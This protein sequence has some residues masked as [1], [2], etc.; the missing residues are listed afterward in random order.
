MPKQRKRRYRVRT[1]VRLPPA[2]WVFMV[3]TV[4]VGLA[5]GKSQLAL[6]FILFGVMMGALY[7]SVVLAWRMVSRVDVRRDV[8]DRAWQNQTVHLGYHLR[9]LRRRGTCLGLSVE[10]IAP[11][12]L[13]SAGGYCVELA[14]K[15]AFRAGARFTV[16]RRGRI[17]LTAIRLATSFPFGLACV[18]RT[19]PAAA[20]VVVWPARG[21][22]KRQVLYHGAVETSSSAPSGDTGGQDEFFGLREYRPGDNPRWIHW[23]R[24]ATKATPVVREMSRPLPEVL[25]VVLDTRLPDHSEISYAARERLLRFAG[26]LIDRALSSGLRVGL[27]LAYNGRIKVLQPAEGLGQRRC[28]LDALADVDVNTST[29][30]DQTL[31]GLSRGLLRQAQVVVAAVDGPGLRSAQLGAL[32]GACRHL[33]VITEQTLADVFE[34]DSLAESETTDAA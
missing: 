24:S 11:E 22:L 33:S 17:G 18:T 32:R 9:N 1:R 6:V 25:W 7:V 8:P 13:D 12:G 15:A 4:F 3:I 14:P 31:S 16:R 26:T 5:A 20:S 34:D 10:E 21:R 27:A 19:I 29:S 28:L 30:L 23:R 2:G